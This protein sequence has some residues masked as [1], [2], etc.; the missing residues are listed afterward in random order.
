MK[1][2]AKI[3][4]RQY[5]LSGIETEGDNFKKSL[6]LIEGDNIQIEVWKERN[7]N[8]HKKYFALI[9][10]TIHH[11]PEAISYEFRNIDN[12]RKYVTI[13]TGRFDLIPSLKGDPIPEAH[14][15]S[16]KSMDNEAFESLY[17]DSLYIILKH[18]FKR[19]FSGRF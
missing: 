3:K 2:I 9:K 19:H 18:F 10:C 7:I 17:S 14:S 1:I 15:I 6:K 11:M 5:F 13:L 12:L 16:F 4:E 8:F